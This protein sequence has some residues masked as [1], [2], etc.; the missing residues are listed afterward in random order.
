MAEFVTIS[1]ENNECDIC[2]HDNGEELIS[3]ILN[4]RCLRQQEIWSRQAT[5]GDEQVRKAHQLCLDRW[6]HIMKKSL[7]RLSPLRRSW[8]CGKQN[9]SLTKTNNSSSHEN[10]II[11]RTWTEIKDDSH[12]HITTDTLKRSEAVPCLRTTQG[13]GSIITKTSD[14]IRSSQLLQRARDVSKHVVYSKDDCRARK[15]YNLCTL[16]THN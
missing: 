11:S 5:S 9:S 6:D 3:Y 10:L 1:L 14:I 12:K 7:N 15:Y 2:H 4:D 16:I 8:S 13:V